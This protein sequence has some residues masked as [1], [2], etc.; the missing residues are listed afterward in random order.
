MTVSSQSQEHSQ[1]AAGNVILICAKTALAQIFLCQRHHT[2][3]AIGRL[4][5]NFD[6]PNPMHGRSSGCQN[7]HELG[8]LHF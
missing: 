7:G 1:W 6:P 2:R 4:S 3:N 5:Q 8:I